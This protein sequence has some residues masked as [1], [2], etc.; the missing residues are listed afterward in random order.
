MSLFGGKKKN[1]LLAVSLDIGKEFV[2]ALVFEVWTE[3]VMFAVAAMPP[4]VERLQAE[5]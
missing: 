1:R 4:K 2:K 3:L 5:E